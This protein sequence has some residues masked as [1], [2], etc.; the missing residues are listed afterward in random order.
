MMWLP[1]TESRRPARRIVVPPEWIRQAD[2]DRAS[3]HARFPEL[4]A[5][6]FVSIHR[7]F[8][9]LYQRVENLS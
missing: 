3:L 4:F 9:K 2:A 7:L 8:D 5:G 1:A 6:G